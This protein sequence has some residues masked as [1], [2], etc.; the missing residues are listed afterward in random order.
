MRILAIGDI[1]GCFTALTTLETYVPFTPSDRLIALG[2]YVD[3]GPDGRAVLDWLIAHKAGGRL[4]PLRGNHE[5]MMCAAR[6]SEQHYDDW[7]ACGGSAALR[8]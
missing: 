8:S 1:H 7:I 6:R 2:D 4:I 5:I 3:R